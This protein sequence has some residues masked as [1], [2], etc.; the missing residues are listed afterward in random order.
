MRPRLNI[1]NAVAWLALF[2]S[3]AGTGLAAS[4][5][6]IT[7][8]SQIKPSVRRALRGAEGPRGPAGP[9]GIP[10][11][12]GPAGSQGAPGPQASLQRLCESIYRAYKDHSGITYEG[13]P[14]V[15]VVLLELY[16][17]SCE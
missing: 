8:T 15:T 10:G 6:I 14:A 1:H 12:A 17:G 13:P 9:Q 3:L 7:S 5:Y 16:T 11:P 4:R 2:F